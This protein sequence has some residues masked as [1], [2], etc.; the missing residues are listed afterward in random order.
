M[1]FEEQT[2]RC[3][4]GGPA[5]LRLVRVSQRLRKE[6]SIAFISGDVM[7]EVGYYCL[8]IA[9]CLSVSPWVVCSR[10]H[11]FCSEMA[12]QGTQTF[13]DKLSTILSKKM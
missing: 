8:F 7:T 5:D 4:A 6:I 13:A 2:E 9:F 12:I 10:C 3:G 1:P 11:V